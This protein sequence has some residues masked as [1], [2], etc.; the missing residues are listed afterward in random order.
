MTLDIYMI[1]SMGKCKSFISLAESPLLTHC[2]HV[3]R[4][5]KCKYV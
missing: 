1:I 3:I 4:I 2:T 5:N